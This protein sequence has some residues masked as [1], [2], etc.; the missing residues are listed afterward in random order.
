MRRYFHRNMNNEM[1]HENRYKVI[2]SSG[3]YNDVAQM[4]DT[5]CASA[6][7]TAQ[8]IGDAHKIQE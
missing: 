8:R 4:E 5:S 6:D 7:A 1:Q 3:R 2:L